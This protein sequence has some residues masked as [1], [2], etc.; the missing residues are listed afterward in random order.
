MNVK[1]KCRRTDVAC[2]ARFP[3]ETNTIMITISLL[4]S[5]A[6]FLVCETSGLTSLANSRSR[7]VKIM[8]TKLYK[9]K[10]GKAIPLQ[11]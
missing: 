9:G 7:N 6:V 8:R 4:E 11:A 5:T 10:K 3:A 1:T 2:N